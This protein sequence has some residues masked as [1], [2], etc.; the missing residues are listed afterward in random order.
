MQSAARCGDSKTLYS[1]MKRVYGPT[2]NKVAPVRDESGELMRDVTEINK[3]WTRHFDQLLNRPS[4][5]EQ[6]AIE[7]MEQRDEITELAERL[8]PTEIEE[9]INALQ[10]DKAAGPDGVPPS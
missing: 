3:R 10:R 2:T 6:S 1:E 9:A 8:D 4:S 7:E 5:I